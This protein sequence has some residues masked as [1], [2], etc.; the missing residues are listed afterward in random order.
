MDREEPGCQLMQEG[1]LGQC[2]IIKGCRHI[3][4]IPTDMMSALNAVKDRLGCSS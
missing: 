3:D 1:A 4:T 2:F